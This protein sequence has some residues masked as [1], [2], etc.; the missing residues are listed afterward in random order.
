M[1]ILG[2]FLNKQQA[3]PL[4][5]DNVQPAF[6]YWHR[7]ELSCFRSFRGT[8]IIRL[9]RR[10]TVHFHMVPQLKLSININN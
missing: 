7:E 8:Y 2:L 5:I 9:K 6:G 10:K 3:V 4:N 1:N